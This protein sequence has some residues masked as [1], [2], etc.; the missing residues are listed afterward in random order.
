MTNRKDETMKKA[1]I[2]W[3]GKQTGQERRAELRGGAKGTGAVIQVVN[4]WPH[5]GSSVDAAYDIF[6]EVAEREGYEIVGTD[7][8]E[9]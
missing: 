3:H 7:R 8:D 6:Q 1:Y 4:Y 5:S 9:E 2:K